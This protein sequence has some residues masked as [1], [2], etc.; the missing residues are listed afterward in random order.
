MGHAAERV[1]TRLKEAG[2]SDDQIVRIW[3][4]AKKE[5]AAVRQGTSEAVHVHS[6]P[7]RVTCSDGSTGTEVF[8]I[9]RDGWIVTVMLRGRNQTT[10]NLRVDRVKSLAA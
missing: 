5:S 10:G 2:L 7:A 3:T 6:L 1:A 8:I 4:A 9:I